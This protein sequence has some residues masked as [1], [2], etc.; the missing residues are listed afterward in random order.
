MDRLY[1]AHAV[2]WREAWRREAL[3]W[4]W[5]WRGGGRERGK[6]RERIRPALLSARGRWE[7]GPAER[8]RGAVGGATRRRRRVLDGAGWGEEAER[9][10]GSAPLGEGS[11]EGEGEA[12]DL[13]TRLN[14]E[15]RERADEGR[16]RGE[17]E[18]EE[19]AE[20]EEEG[21]VGLAGKEVLAVG[22]GSERERERGEAESL[23]ES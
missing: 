17:D 15:G 20:E 23:G 16:R 4:G 3:P 10:G 11:G 6:R 2:W 13:A 5:L 7:R 22:A 12:A 9:G 21:E 19:A 14:H 1:T 18:T 8:R